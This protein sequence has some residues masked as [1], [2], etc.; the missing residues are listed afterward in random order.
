MAV[1]VCN[2]GVLRWFLLPGDT[3]DGYPEASIPA[4]KALAAEN[5]CELE[6]LRSHK[7]HVCLMLLPSSPS[8]TPRAGC[9]AA[10]DATT[11]TTTMGVETADA[12]ACI[13]AARRELLAVLPALPTPYHH[14]HHHH[15][16]H[17]EEEGGGGLCER[18]AAA[19]AAGGGG[20][21]LDNDDQK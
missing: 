9:A 13:T 8:P 6:A 15:H 20:A 7:G 12:T 17:A 14:P 19:A 10:A 5:A 4:F 16:D 11:T 18:G 1:S 3:R 2:G 21:T